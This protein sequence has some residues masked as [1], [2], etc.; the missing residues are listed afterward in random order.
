MLKHWYVFSE[1]EYKYLIGMAN[2]IPGMASGRNAHTQLQ[3]ALGVSQ[4]LTVH[5]IFFGNVHLGAETG[6]VKGKNNLPLDGFRR[7]VEQEHKSP[8]FQGWTDMHETIPVP[9]VCSP[10]M[11]Q[12]CIED[13][14]LFF[15]PGNRL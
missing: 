15:V 13:V 7:W 4:L 2:D 12:R 6:I 11:N 9:P 5:S 1:M 8:V 14:S 3:V 10:Q